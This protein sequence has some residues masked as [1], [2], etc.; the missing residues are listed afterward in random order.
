[1]VQDSPPP[2]VVVAMSHVAKIDVFQSDRGLAS[3]L[4]ASNVK[5]EWAKEFLGFHKLE[6][7]DDLIF[8]VTSNNWEAGIEEMCKQ[9]RPIADNR[10]ALARFRSAY[11]AGQQAI[12]M[13]AQVASQT[14][15][16]SLDELLPQ[17]TSE[18]LTKDFAARYNLTVDPAL[19]PS[20]QLRARVYREF[21]KGTISVIPINK[22]KSILTSSG[23]KNQEAVSLPGGLQ[24]QF[25]REL[26][27]DVSSV[28]SYYCGMRTLMHAWAWAGNYQ[29]RDIDGRDSSMVTLSQALG[30]ADE[31]LRACYEY[32]SSSLVWL[33]RNDH[34][35]RGKVASLVR[36]GYNVGSALSEAIREHHLEW[37]SPAQPGLVTPA[38]V[39]PEKKR[40]VEQVESAWGEKKEQRRQV[41]TDKHQT[42]S[43]LKGGQ[44]LCKPWNDSRGCPGHCG[45]KHCCDVKMPNGKPC[46]ATSHNRMS[47]D[48]AVE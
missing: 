32:G 43:M 4:K 41:K 34:I 30:Y 7:L 42:V 3:C 28:I 38:V 33:Q 5:D 40:K 48:N 2:K 26:T 6:T 21:R 37:R 25:D 46:L 16:E 1:M 39:G 14:S 23:P 44:R 11:E 36:R 20:D 8:S 18:Q 27:V 10:I 22:V 12:K 17:S 19:E 15:P 35:T 31:A 24:L 47:H 45:Q 9:V 13:A 29:C